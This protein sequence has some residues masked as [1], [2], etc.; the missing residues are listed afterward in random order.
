MNPYS[1]GHRPILSHVPE[2]LEKLKSE[3]ESLAQELSVYKMQRDE[4][5]RKLQQHLQESQNLQNQIFELERKHKKIVQNL[6]DEIL[7]L[8]MQLGTGEHPVINRGITGE[9]RSICTVEGTKEMN[10][11]NKRPREIL[12]PLSSTNSLSSTSENENKPKRHEIDSEGDDWV[13]GYNSAVSTR[14]LTIQLKHDLDHSSVVCCVKFSADGKYLATGCNHTAQIYNV[15]TGKKVHTYKEQQTLDSDLY[16]RSVCFSPDIKYLATGA[17]DK[18]VKLW[19]IET[20]TVVHNLQGHEKD[21]YS[22]DFTKDGRLVVSGSGDK[23]VKVWDVSHA[24]KC[25]YT[26]GDND[27]GA[28][29]GVTSVVVSP[30][31]KLVAAGSLDRIIRL[32]DLET[33][34]FIGQYEGHTDSVY[35]V[36]F[37]PDGKTLASGSLDQTV[38]LWD[39]N[40]QKR[41]QSRATLS[42][43]RDFV[44]SVAFSPDG[45]WLVS[46][47]KD[48]SVQFW[49]PRQNLAHLILQGH[50]NSVISVALVEAEEREAGLFATGSGDFRAR[51]WKYMSTGV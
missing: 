24:A 16:I 15:K 47:S 22:L 2:L 19:N 35:S 25:V 10:N 37:S 49:D 42:G 9:K 11:N 34:T 3:Y 5:E 13:L 27:N 26:L 41:I 32:W 1:H 46:G 12:P 20:E 8:R 17:E 48:R 7:H 6:E 28:T 51:I 45:K 40:R 43:H 14:K 36:A 39:V 33:G 4:F 18:S 44:L 29:D 38:K 23:T 30:D 31:G 21:I 50:R